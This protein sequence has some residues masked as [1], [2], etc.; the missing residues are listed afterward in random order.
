MKSVT[1]LVLMASMALFSTL[2]KASTEDLL[3]ASCQAFNTSQES[4]LPCRYYIHGFLAG[5]VV[6]DAVIAME[7]KEEVNKRSSFI[8]RAYRTRVGQADSRMQETQF[9]HFCVPDEESKES[10]VDRLSK[11]F[12]HPLETIEMLKTTVYNALS[13]EYP[14]R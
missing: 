6:T 14:C 7:R 1:S 12:L 13:A 11:R 5:A 2:V 3:L 9:M 8:E 10:I 4:T